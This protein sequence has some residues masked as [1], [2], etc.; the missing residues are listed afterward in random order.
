M[1]N[2]TSAIFTK[3]RLTQRCEAV[4]LARDAGLG[5]DSRELGRVCQRPVK[6]EC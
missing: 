3:L 6:R 5:R 4:V 1:A 2:H